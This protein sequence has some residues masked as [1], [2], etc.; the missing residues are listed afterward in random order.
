MTPM[1]H[2]A[3]A[4]PCFS[5]GLMSISTICDMGTSAAPK[6]PCSRRAPTIWPREFD[7]PH[8]AE[9]T[10]NPTTDARK[11]CFC[12]KRSTSQ[13][14]NGVAIAAATMYAV[15]TQAI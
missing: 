11:I 4:E 8:K 7:R 9:A 13:P 14:V 1:P 5:G 6:T 15:N 10:V 12:P 2:T 3:I